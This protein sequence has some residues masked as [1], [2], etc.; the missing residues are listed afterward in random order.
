LAP[1]DV[2]VTDINIFQP[3][4]ALVLN[5]HRSRVTECGIEGPPDLVVE[6]ISPSTARYDE[7]S[8]RK[9]Y[10]RAG[11]QEFWLVR[12]ELREIVKY[13]LASSQTAGT[14][15]SGKSKLRSTVLSGFQLSV[16]ALFKG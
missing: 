14:S 7:G 12:P 5:E 8:K 9:V 3:D 13:S 11:V 1:L 16:S 6:I 10:E 2:F 4:L 15:H